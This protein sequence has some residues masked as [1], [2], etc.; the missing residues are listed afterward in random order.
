MQKRVCGLGGGWSC[1]DNSPWCEPKQKTN[2][3]IPKMGVSAI[4]CKICRR[5]EPETTQ[6]K[7]KREGGAGTT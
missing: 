6:R 1:I 7:E 2:R 4:K 5:D 3:E